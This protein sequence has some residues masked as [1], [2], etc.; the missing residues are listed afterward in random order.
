MET[1]DIGSENI[2]RMET[3]EELD[4]TAQSTIDMGLKHGSLVLI[5]N[6]HVLKNRNENE[7]HTYKIL[8]KYRALLA[9]GTPIIIYP[10]IISESERFLII[11]RLG[12]PFPNSIQEH[13]GYG[14]N[15]S[16]QDFMILLDGIDRLRKTILIDKTENVDTVTK[17]LGFISNRNQSEDFIKTGV[18]NYFPSIRELYLEVEEIIGNVQTFFSHG[19]IVRGNFHI[20]NGTIY[21]IDWESSHWSFIGSDEG[22]LYVQ[23]SLSQSQQELLA[24]VFEIKYRNNLSAQLLFWR[25]AVTR[26]Y[27]E[28]GFLSTGKYSERIYRSFNDDFSRNN[29]KLLLYESLRK[30]LDFSIS[31]MTTLIK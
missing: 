3:G 8:E 11:T 10:E 17:E 24:K 23:L 30:T 18:V 9:T 12:Y 2:L 5:G 19:D 7:V 21:F 25:T 20:Q 6:Y 28:L 14:S 31:L 13:F 16:E 26:A 4:Y 22:R 15:Y 1:N 29:F 27:K